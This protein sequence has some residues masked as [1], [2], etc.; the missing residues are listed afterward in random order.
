MEINLST[1]RTSDAR[2]KMSITSTAMV[3]IEPEIFGLRRKMM[4]AMIGRSWHRKA[5]IVFKVR[6]GPCGLYFNTKITGTM[7]TAREKYKEYG[8]KKKVEETM[9]VLTKYATIR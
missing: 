3:I 2:T 6:K 4:R 5:V 7:E 9:T 8:E 1:E